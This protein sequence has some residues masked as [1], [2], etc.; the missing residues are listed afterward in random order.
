MSE[1]HETIEL[2]E[3]PTSL[4]VEVPAG[5]LTIRPS[6]SRSLA[7]RIEG[8][9]ADLVVVDASAG[10]VALRV[11]SPS[12]FGASSLRI[13]VEAPAGIDL[14]V[15]SASLDVHSTVDLGSVT[16]ATASGDVRLA[17]VADLRVKAASGDIWVAGVGTVRASVASGDLRTGDVAGDLEVSAASGDVFADT[18]AGRVDV[19]T[20]S[21]DVRIGRWTGTD[22]AIKSVSGDV[23]VT[24]PPGTRADLDLKTLSGDVRMPD[25]PS[26][27][28][29]DEER[30]RRRLRFSSVSGTFDLRVGD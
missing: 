20:A 3:G 22:L 23:L 2:P 26:A 1:R 21:G 19:R 6:T 24:V 27:S 15:R 18:V 14:E 17:D 12:R 13:A 28:V 29:P 10:R 25:G 16:V 30:V 4:V 9:D 8:R 5:A 11:D 7:V